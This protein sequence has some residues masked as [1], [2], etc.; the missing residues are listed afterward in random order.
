VDQSVR[1]CLA[2]AIVATFLGV[3]TV[4]VYFSISGYSSWGDVKDVLQWWFNCYSLLLGAIIGY[5]FRDATL[6]LE[7]KGQQPDTTR[8]GTTTA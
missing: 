4:L 1:A 7:K 2:L 6:S 8:Q 3:S 5:Y